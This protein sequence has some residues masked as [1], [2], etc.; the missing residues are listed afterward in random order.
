MTYA[1]AYPMALGTV[2]ATG[3][4]LLFRRGDLP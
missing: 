3:G 2:A 1:I 4:Y